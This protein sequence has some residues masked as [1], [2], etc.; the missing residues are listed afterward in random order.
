MQHITSG[1]FFITVIIS[2]KIF[3]TNNERKIET[4]IF[5]LIFYYY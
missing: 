1:N 5:I 4:S 3:P 2:I